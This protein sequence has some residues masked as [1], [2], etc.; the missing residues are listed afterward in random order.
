MSRA[1]SDAW[2]D[3]QEAVGVDTGALM[4]VHVGGLHRAS[5]GCNLEAI[6]EVA[7]ALLRDNARERQGTRADG[8]PFVASITVSRASVTGA[9]HDLVAVRD[10]TERLRAED[11][12][13]CSLAEK[14]TLVQEVHHRVKNNLQML[15]SLASLQADSLDDPQARSALDDTVYRIQSMALVHPQLYA[16]D[17]LARVDFDAYARELCGSLRASLAPDATLTV[18]A[19]RVT[20]PV[21]RAVPAGLILNELVTNAFK[22]GRSADGHP[23]VHVEVHAAGAGFVFAVHDEGPGLPTDV[24][25]PGSMGATLIAALSRRLRARRSQVP[26]AGSGNSLRIEVPS[27]G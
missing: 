9:P 21:D 14:V 8:T 27:R 19:E 11:A 6:L 13:R 12:L 22:Y 23:R 18:D 25:R 16:R 7:T 3:A 20:L 24:A 15:S 10:L 1:A 2:R 5:G 17:D 26:S 4:S